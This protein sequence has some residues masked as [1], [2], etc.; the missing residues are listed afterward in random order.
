P[1]DEIAGLIANG[2]ITHSLVV[3]AFYHYENYLKEHGGK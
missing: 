1:L 3:A 2:R